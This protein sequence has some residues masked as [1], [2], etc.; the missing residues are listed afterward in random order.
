VYGIERLAQSTGLLLDLYERHPGERLLVTYE[1]LVSDPDGGLT[2]ILRFVLAGASVDDRAGRAAIA[3]SRFGRMRDWE[4]NL[5][6]EEARLRYCN[7]FGPRED[8]ASEDGHF[9]VR[10]GEVGAFTSEMSPQLQ[11]HVAGLPHTAALIQ[12][13]AAVRA[14]SI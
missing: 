11:R 8:A 6:A 2:R 4:R 10:R 1:D 3:A 14:R 13:L 7:R 5:T 12:R 9:K